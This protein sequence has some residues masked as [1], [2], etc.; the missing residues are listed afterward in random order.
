MP[1]KQPI[2]ITGI[3]TGVGKTIVS[4]IITEKLKAD[5]WKPIQSGDLDDSD[6]LK[7]K[8]LVSNDVTVFHP[9]AYRLTQPFSPHKS[10]AIDKVTIDMQSFIIPKTENQLVIE[11]AGG[12]MVPLNDNFLMIDLIKQLNAKVILVSKNYLGSINHTL[13]SI[14]ALKNYNIEVMGIVFNGPKDIYSKTYILNYSGLTELGQ[15]PMYPKPG[16]KS[17]LEAT[18]LISL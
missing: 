1:A 4:A 2:F 8:S 5:Y 18:A 15:I 12:L 11:G 6:T 14:Q 13:L 9:E 16:K 17:I 10:A 3:G 7:V